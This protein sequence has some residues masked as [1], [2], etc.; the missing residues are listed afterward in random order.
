[1]LL[2]AFLARQ[3]GDGQRVL[4]NGAAVEAVQIDSLSLPTLQI[5]Q[6][7]W[8]GAWR[9]CRLLNEHHTNYQGEGRSC[10]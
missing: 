5:Q 8:L 4:L 9:E 1:M 3:A 6:I 7:N 10:D 2:L